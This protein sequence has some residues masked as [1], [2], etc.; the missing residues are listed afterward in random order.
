MK[1]E[2]VNLL[3]EPL[4]FPPRV[5]CREKREERREVDQ[6]TDMDEASQKR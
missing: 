1:Q 4:A 2:K 5:E 6:S 3:S